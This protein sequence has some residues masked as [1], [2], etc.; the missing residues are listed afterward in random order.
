MKLDEAPHLKDLVTFGQNVCEPVHNWY[1][2]KEGFSKGLA[3][4]FIDRFKLKGLVLDPFCGVGTTLL[5]CKQAGLSSVGVDVS[6]LFVFVS[7]VKTRD[8]DLASLGEAV[9]RSLK[10]KFE[11]PAEVPKE[12]WLKRAF[13]KYAL[14]EIGRAHV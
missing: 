6:P 4:F 5:A 11:K 12:A 7:R 13:S 10:W 14:E 3:D 1:F 2:Y 8:Y 9:K